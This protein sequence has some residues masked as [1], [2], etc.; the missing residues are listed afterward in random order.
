M[1]EKVETPTNTSE[2][3]KNN[4]KVQGLKVEWHPD[5]GEPDVTELD[6]SEQGF[7]DKSVHTLVWKK[8]KGNKYSDGIVM[9]VDGQVA[10]SD[11]KT[12]G[13]IRVKD[14]DDKILIEQS[15]GKGG[16]GKQIIKVTGGSRISGVKQSSS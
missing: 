4:K 10:Y 6:L 13:Y 5:L 9:I 8:D 3:G 15:G 11:L 12:S 7:K 1:N 14:P 16:S 2:E